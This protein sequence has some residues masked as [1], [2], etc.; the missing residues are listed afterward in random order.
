MS[1]TNTG[2]SDASTSSD[3]STPSS[4]CRGGSVCQ[5]PTAASSVSTILICLL[6]PTTIILLILGTITYIVWRRNKREALEDNDPNFI[7]D[8]EL[9]PV[10]FGARDNDN[11]YP[12]FDSDSKLHEWKE[13]NGRAVYKRELI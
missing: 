6:L 4:E 8:A 1:R 2:S 13:D 9:I 5:R 7:G 3:V 12:N 10:L 11:T